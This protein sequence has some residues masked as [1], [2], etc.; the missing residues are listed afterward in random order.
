MAS[1]VPMS[2]ITAYDVQPFVSYICVRNHFGGLRASVLI[3]VSS[4]SMSMSRELKLTHLWM[5]ALR[6]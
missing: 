5:R 4:M 2:F 3:I 6:C 1:H